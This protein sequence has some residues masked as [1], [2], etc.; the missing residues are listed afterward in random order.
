MEKSLRPISFANKHEIRNHIVMYGLLPFLINYMEFNT[1]SILL[2][3]KEVA[4]MLGVTVNTLA[5]WRH[6]KRY[7][8]KY[9][10]SGWL[11]RYRKEDVE[12]FINNQ[13]HDGG[14]DNA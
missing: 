5:A 7:P 6:N 10:K 9:V 4:E 12:A 14:I 8:L 1:M 2:T 11:V 13:T 3:A